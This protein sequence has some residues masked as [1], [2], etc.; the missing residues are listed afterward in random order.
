MVSKY[1]IK[2]H[3]GQP[4]HTC[5]LKA[6]QLPPQPGTTPDL[7]DVNKENLLIL[8]VVPGRSRSRTSQADGVSPRKRQETDKNYTPSN[9]LR[10]PTVINESDEELE[11]EKQPR[12]TPRSVLRPDYAELVANKDPWN[13]LD[14][15][16]EV[17]YV[18]EPCLC[19]AIA[20][21]RL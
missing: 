19:T 6:L 7:D 18:F 1:W 3:L 14:M 2:E 15:D 16:G 11:A 10:N 4:P 12:R 5:R 17:C 13:L 20:D 21:M 9:K 8:V